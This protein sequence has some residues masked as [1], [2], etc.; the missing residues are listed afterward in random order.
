MQRMLEEH[1]FDYVESVYF[2]HRL[3]AAKV[4]NLGGKD[5]GA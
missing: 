2:S 1:D 4:L 5:G 3:S